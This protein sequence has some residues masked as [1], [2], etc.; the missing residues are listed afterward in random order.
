MTGIRKRI[1]LSFIFIIV[2]TVLLLEILILNMLKQNF[3]ANLE[4]T[5]TSQIKVSASIYSKYFADNTLYDNVL[6]NVDSFWNQSD[7]QVQIID[8]DGNVLMDSIGVIPQEGQRMPD[9]EKALKDGRGTWTGKV[10]YDEDGVMAVSCLLTSEDSVVGVLRF[11]TSLKQIKKDVND[12]TALF[13]LIGFIAAIISVLVSLILANTVVEP[14]RNVTKV[15]ERMA[16]GD[17]RIHS[18]K[19][20]NDEIG[21]LSDTLNYMAEEILKREGL[22]NDFISSVSHELRT[23]LTSIKGWAAT[24][25]SEENNDKELLIEGLGI[26]EK[27]SDRLTAMV[28]ELLDFSRFVSERV[29]MEKTRVNIEEIM[30]HIGRQLAPRAERESLDFQVQIQQGLPDLDTDPNRLKQVFINVLDNAFKF[31]RIGGMVLFSSEKGTQDA[32]GTVVFKISDTGC[33]ID[34]SE[35]P[36]IKEKFIKGKHSKAGNGIG[37]SICEEIISLMGGTLVINSVLNIGTEV[38]ITLPCNMEDK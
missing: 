33:G 14:L 30:R 38:V 15:A 32:G 1:A 28:D 37:L 13:I 35:L 5:L 25:S 6:N 7:V 26:I 2:L 29:Q 34:S 20:Y 3:Y 8:T 22:K 9:V 18:D 27:E 10:S 36:N 16:K 23:P 4:D 17:F 19:V 21:K 31:N 11:V 12:I 24:L